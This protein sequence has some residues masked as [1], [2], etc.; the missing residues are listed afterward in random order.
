MAILVNL[1][2]PMNL[3]E[4]R[5]FCEVATYFKRFIRMYAKLSAHLYEVLKGNGAFCWGAKQQKVFERVKEALTI[6]PVLALP[7]IGEPFELWVDTSKR[8]IGGMLRQ[9]GHPI[10]FKSRKLTKI[11]QR[12]VNHEQEMYA[13]I[14]C[15]KK[16]DF[17]LVPDKVA[18][19]TDNIASSYFETQHKEL[20]PK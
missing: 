16:W 12:W 1:P 14:Y 17:Y 15:L 20:S 13:I 3:P 2:A 5:G 10:A 7:V 4:L 9:H 8:A 6:A 18:V 19:F 11:E